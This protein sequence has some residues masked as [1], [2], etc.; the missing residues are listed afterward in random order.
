MSLLNS[1]KSMFT[2]APRAFPA[3]VAPRVRSGEALLVD[4]REPAEWEHGVAET[5][6]LLPLSDLGGARTYW[7]DLLAKA[8]DRQVL[9]YCASG[10]RSNQAAR[11]LAAEG[12]Q[13]FN[14][15]GLGD[16]AAAGWRIVKPRSKGR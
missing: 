13:A 14:A 3:E 6:A 4:V 11:V 15:G 7:R 1:L 5:A 9:V 2:P 12:I 8:G 16:W 10:M